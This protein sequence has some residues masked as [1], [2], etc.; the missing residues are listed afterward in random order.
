MSLR[1]PLPRP[2]QRQPGQSPAPART[3]PPKPGFR[4]VGSQGPKPGSSLPQ[5]CN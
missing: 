5:K 1:T 4:K 2:V 3:Q